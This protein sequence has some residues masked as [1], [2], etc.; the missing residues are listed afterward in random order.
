MG[1]PS[2]D[3]YG[4]HLKLD[5]SEVYEGVRLL[6]VILQFLAQF[7]ACCEDTAFDRAQRQIHLCCDF[8]I[9]VSGYI[10]VE[11]DTVIVGK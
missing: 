4:K 1:F 9:L 5:L 3:R 7:L 6:S 2:E 11:G 8:V 10:H